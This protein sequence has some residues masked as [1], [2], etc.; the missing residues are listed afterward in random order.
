M[1]LPPALA[2]RLAKRGI[3]KVTEAPKEA[4]ETPEPPLAAQSKPQPAAAPAEEIIAEDY[5]EGLPQAAQEEP[6]P[7]AGWGLCPNKWN[8]YHDCTPTCRELW[9]VPRPPSPSY[10][11]K[12][13]RMLRKHPLPPNW[14]EVWEAGLARHYYW[15]P[16]KGLVSWL[17]PSHPRSQ[18]TRGVTELR[19]LLHSERAQHGTAARSDEEDAGDESSSE[20]SDSDED[21]DAERRS[22][23]SDATDSM[24]SDDDDGD[25]PASPSGR[26]TPPPPPPPPK[27]DAPPPTAPTP[28]MPAPPPPAKA[29]PPPKGRGQ[30]RPRPQRAS[31][32]ALDPM[33]PAAYGDCPRGGWSAGLPDRTDAKTGVDSTV[34][35]PLFQQRPYPS[36]GAV[37]RN[38]QQPGPMLPPAAP[39]APKG[40]E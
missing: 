18:V 23:H 2:A 38:N 28:A 40:G 36:P 21:S 13:R 26:L 4:V 22:R 11:R 6:Q 33:D 8:V 34:S 10:E 20:S 29:P 1:P 15:N 32:D 9:A 17:A 14:L 31:G 7:Y 16:A 5:D 39:P 24:S 37:L 12:R 30:K 35:G 25:D 3:I 19:R 27:A